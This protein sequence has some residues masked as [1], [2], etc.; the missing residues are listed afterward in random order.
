MLG[1]GHGGRWF[2]DLETLLHSIAVQRHGIDPYTL[3]YDIQHWYSHWWLLLEPTGVSRA[4]TLWLGAVIT[5]CVVAAVCLL[6]RPRTLGE[7][8]WTLAVFGS[9][10]ILLGLNRANIDL[11]LFLILGPCV[12]ALM[13][14]RRLV[15]LLAA[16]ALI[17]LAA[18]LKYY[19]AVAGLI[20]L[21]LPSRRER[22]ISLCLYAGLLLLVIL[23]VAGDIK[24]YTGANAV[25]GLFTFGAPLAFGPL[26]LTTTIGLGLTLGFLGASGLG[27][28]RALDLR[29]PLAPPERSRDHLFFI[30]GAIVLTGCFVASTNYAYRW[31]FSFWMLPFLIRLRPASS[32]RALCW[33]RNA[34]IALLI[35]VLWTEGLVVVALNIIPHTL[36]TNI[37]CQEVANLTVQAM[38]WLLFACLS[39]W[40]AHFVLMAGRGGPDPAG[41]RP[42]D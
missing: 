9:A 12:P 39:G 18:G 29:N 31:I 34:T 26:G 1:V 21:A 19:P 25:Q 33:L 4:D 35:A 3:P 14:S 20:L 15:R 22:A 13:S 36:A 40:L 27:I 23:S 2:L 11:V 8:C 41:Q 5:A 10:P 38:T 32:R 37:R 17:A 28:A 7:V 24:H 6:V 42:G 16:P 30:L